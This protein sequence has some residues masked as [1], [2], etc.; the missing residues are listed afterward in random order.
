MRY[1]IRKPSLIMMIVLLELLL[2]VL[3]RLNIVVLLD[4]LL[5]GRLTIRVLQLVVKA[6][7]LLMD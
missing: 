2:L 3:L 5:E 7:E 6:E 1:V 4:C